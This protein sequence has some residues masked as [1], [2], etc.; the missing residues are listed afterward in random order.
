MKHMDDDD[1]VNYGNFV[2]SLRVAFYLEALVV[3]LGMLLYHI[4]F[5]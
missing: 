5:G 2:H 3:V 1:S 4:L